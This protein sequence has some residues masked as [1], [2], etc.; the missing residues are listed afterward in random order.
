MSADSFAIGAAKASGTSSAVKSVLNIVVSKFLYV[1]R[2]YHGK[3][4]WRGLKQSAKSRCKRKKLGF[5]RSRTRG[6]T[7]D[8]IQTDSTT[9][10][11]D[12]SL[13]CDRHPHIQLGTI[14]GGL[15]D[16]GIVSEYALLPD[17]KQVAR[18]TG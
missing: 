17:R 5:S 11:Q 18:P 6:Y 7:L 15:E 3:S 2:I 4:E 13:T 12:M 10:S 8:V 14:F 1:K 9:L 16:V